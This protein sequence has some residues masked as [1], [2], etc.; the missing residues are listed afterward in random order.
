MLKSLFTIVLPI[1]TVAAFIP[2]LS[3]AYKTKST[4]DVSLG[5][6]SIIM[7]SATLWTIYG[8]LEQDLAVI[9]TNSLIIVIVGMIVA[10]KLRY[11]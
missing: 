11:G 7:S 5:T 10:M 1:L 8:L 4:K 6:F 3:K 2:Q 9:I